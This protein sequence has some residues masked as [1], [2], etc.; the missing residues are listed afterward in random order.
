MN[1]YTMEDYQLE[2]EVWEKEHVEKYL[3]PIPIP[4]WM[5]R[6]HGQG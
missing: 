4:N 2:I 6:V 3:N 5:R 1:G